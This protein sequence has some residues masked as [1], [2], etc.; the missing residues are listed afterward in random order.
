MNRI[1]FHRIIKYVIIFLLSFGG[2]YCAY[3]IGLK[4]RERR[5]KKANELK[6]DDYEYIPEINKDI[7][8]FNNNK[9]KKFLELNMKF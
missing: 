3:Y 7:N 9:E 5:R 4:A 8:N 1:S 2:L 6:D